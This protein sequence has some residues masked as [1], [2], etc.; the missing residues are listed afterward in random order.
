VF[1]PLIG[2]NFLPLEICDSLFPLNFLL[3]R[4]LEGENFLLK[5]FLLTLYLLWN[6]LLV[7]FLLE[8]LRL[9]LE[10]LERLKL[11]LE[12]LK[13]RFPNDFLE[14]EL[15]LRPPNDLFLA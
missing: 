5:L 1:F 15:F 7:I 2:L 8:K 3:F 12:R 11:L 10:L 9:K 13:L 4:F 14:N 6:L